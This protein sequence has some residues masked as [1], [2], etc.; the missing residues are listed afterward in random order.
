MFGNAS[1]P[2]VEPPWRWGY[3]EIWRFRDQGL[4]VIGLAIYQHAG[5]ALSVVTMIFELER[6]S[7]QFRA[8]D[9]FVQ[10]TLSLLQRQ[11]DHRRESKSA[12]SASEARRSSK[13]GRA[14][15]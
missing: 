11:I 5:S 7:G 4:K 1:L 8:E 6:K 12:Q 3:R 13:T 14:R 15:C 9:A 10:A 2:S